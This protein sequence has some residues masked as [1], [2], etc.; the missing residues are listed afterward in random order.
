MQKVF[1]Y[2]TPNAPRGF[3]KNRPPAALNEEGFAASQFALVSST[4]LNPKNAIAL[5]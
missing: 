5:L 2:Y 4:D 3:G 1:S